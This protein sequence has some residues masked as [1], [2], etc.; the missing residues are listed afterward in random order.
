MGMGRQG[1]KEGRGN[2]EVKE[3]RIGIK[4]KNG[5]VAKEIKLVATLYTRGY[6]GSKDRWR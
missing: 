5:R 4:L 1:G 2:R 6:T 3:K